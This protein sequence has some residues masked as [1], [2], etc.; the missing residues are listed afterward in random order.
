MKYP[1]TVLNFAGEAN[2]A[3][4]AQ[5]RDYYNHYRV[6]F[7]GAKN[8]EFSVTD[9]KG[10]PITFEEKEALMN[11]SLKR[12][13]LRVSGIQNFTEFPLA[14]MAT[15]PMLGWATFAVV[16]Q[17][18]DMIL[19]ETIID[20]IG[21]YTDVRTIG[22]GDSA[23]FEVEPK[24]IFAVSKAGRA[25]RSTEIH[26]Q[27]RGNVSIVPEA[28]EL[29]VGVSLYRVLSGHES[30]AIFVSKV[31]RSMETQV[32]LDAYDAFAAAMAA[33]PTTATTG[34]QVAGY[35]QA[36]LVRLCQQVGAWNGGAKPIIMGTQLALASVLPDDANYRYDLQGSDFMK[37]GYVRTAFGYDIMALPQVADHRTE[38]AMR[39]DNDRLWIVSPSAQKLLKLVL[40]GSTV[41]Y[42]D[43]IYDNANLLQRSTILKSYG[44]GVAT[45]SIAG[46][47]TL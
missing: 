29:T 21:M 11:A 20:S 5:F 12:E 16:S 27:F 37:L 47:M 44:V 31:I 39:L 1:A 26:K 3:P 30:L 46:I 17:M 42:T 33:L 8:L 18:I 19:P 36:S 43:N 41:S 14:Q 9:D 22:W 4:Y 25:Q 15:H 38:W 45:N 7:E 10:L 2:L 32:T 40:E 24:D 35:T 28:R 34:L 23:L 13:I 6:N